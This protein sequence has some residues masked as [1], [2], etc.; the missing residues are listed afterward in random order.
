MGCGGHQTVGMPTYTI[1]QLVDDGL[2]EAAPIPPGCRAQTS[3]YQAS[4]ED[5]SPA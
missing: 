5:L 2:L 4:L 1:H 3:V